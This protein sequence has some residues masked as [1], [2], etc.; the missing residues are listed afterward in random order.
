MSTHLLTPAQVARYQTEGFLSPL[1]ALEAPFDAVVRTAAA[2]RPD[3]CIE[4]RK[5]LKRP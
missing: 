1:P 3:P 5:R 2:E 4:F